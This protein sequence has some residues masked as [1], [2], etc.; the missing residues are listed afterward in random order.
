MSKEET[1]KVISE[2]AR[3]T[4]DTGSVEVQVALHTADINKLQKHFE[5]HRKDRHSRRGLIR[6]V[7]LRRKQLK[8]LKCK[9]IDRY[10]ALI[11]KL[12]LRGV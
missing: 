5:V 12:G 8:Y 7:N 11:E 3:G 1:S 10:S 4:G 9:D 6:K 2:H